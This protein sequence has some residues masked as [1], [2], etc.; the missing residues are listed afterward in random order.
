MRSRG[1]TLHRL[2]VWI[3]NQLCNFNPPH[4]SH[5][6]LCLPADAADLRKPAGDTTRR[7]TVA[8]VTHCVTQVARPAL[9]AW[10][11]GRAGAGRRAGWPAA[12]ATRR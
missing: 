3:S 6:L 7:S 9:R 1:L 5:R 12:A 10:T 11:A 4:M 2:P 8:A